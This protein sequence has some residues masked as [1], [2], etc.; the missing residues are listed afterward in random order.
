[1]KYHHTI[2]TRLLNSLRPL[3]VLASFLFIGQATANVDVSLNLWHAYDTFYGSVSL[4]TTN[5]IATYHH[6]ESPNGAIYR[7]AGSSSDGSFANLVEVGALLDECTNGFWTL[8][9]NVGD[10]SEEIYTFSV[11]LSG[12]TSNLFG[13]ASILSP[14][15]DETVTVNPP[16]FQWTGPANFPD[17]YIDI[18]HY[19]YPYGPVDFASFPS[20]TTNWT[21]SAPLTGSHL[22]IF[23]N[24]STNNYA[25]ASFTTP[26]NTISGTP[27][28]AWAA[29]ARLTSYDYSAFHVMGSG[30]DLDDAV[31]SPGLSW[32]TGG[33]NG[34]DSWFVQSDEFTAG[35]NAIQSGYVPDYASSWI[36]TTVQGPGMLIFEWN[37]LA[38]YGDSFDFIAIDE[39][40]NGYDG[41]FYE[42]NEAAGWDYYEV[43]LEPGPNTLR[44]TFFNDDV[45]AN[46]YDAAF[47]DGVEY[48]PEEADYEAE[49][50]LTIQHLIQGTNDFYYMYPY[51]SNAYPEPVEVASP[52]GLSSSSM[53]SHPYATLQELIDEIED[54]DW[55]I[56]FDMY[57][58]SERDFYFDV[59]VDSLTT[60]DFPPVVILEPLDGATGVATNSGYMW[61]GPVSFD[62]LYVYARAINP[63]SQLGSESLPVGD[64]SWTGGPA[65]PS[66]TNSFDATYTSNNFAGLTI[67]EPMDYDYNYLSY[68]S[69]TAKISTVGR[70][71]FVTGSGFVPMAV[72]LLPPIV[73][74]GEFGLSFLSQSGAMHWVEYSTNLVTG[75]WMPATNFPGNG[76][77][78]MLSLPVTN[79]AAYFRVETQ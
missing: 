23:L 14:L 50:V 74:G 57:G 61:I 52:N 3:A 60:N 56:S 76:T 58:P 43:Y 49:F 65:L 16:D 31:G 21:P 48:Y 30:S 27:L 32:T 34:G 63:S 7:N 72:T 1:M 71:R 17:L 36:E 69:T 53:G 5:P 46:D 9:L 59:T 62:E 15:W 42:G 28:A 75:S 25:G 73:G 4:S 24:Y 18:S 77:T 22:D 8:T 10:V 41:F 51:L 13:T 47:L 67:S 39:Y 45:S 2:H 66:G 78:N 11:S 64:T 29:K 54:G 19:D 35:T 44:W 38:D 70:S 33:D 79:S 68:W 12:I 40:E 55:T 20:T 37:M 6:I 26:T